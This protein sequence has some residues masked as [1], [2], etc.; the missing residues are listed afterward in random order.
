M[1]LHAGSGARSTFDVPRAR[2]DGGTIVQLSP[3]TIRHIRHLLTTELAQTL[4]YSLILSRIDYCNAVLHGGPN[5]SINKLQ[6]A[7]NNA[8]RIVLQEPRRSHATPLLKR[9]HRADVQSPQHVDAVVP[10]T[11]D[12]GP[13]AR[14]QPTIRHHVVVST[15]AKHDV[16]EARFPRFSACHLE[17]A[18]EES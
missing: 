15:I 18:L 1:K 7:Q 5:Y 8:S 11:P 9:L 12:Q 14:P 4:A 3:M 10:S 17:L 6:R 2:L 16:C 13:G